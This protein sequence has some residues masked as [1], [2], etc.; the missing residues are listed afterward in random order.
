MM[1]SIFHVLIYHLYICFCSCV[2]L[3]TFF[4]CGAS[5][6]PL[7]SRYGSFVIY[8]CVVCKCFLPSCSLTFHPLNRIVYKKFWILMRPNLSSI[9]FYGSSFWVK[10]KNT[11]TDCLD[12]AHFMVSLHFFFFLKRDWERENTCEQGGAR[13]GAQ[14]QDWVSPL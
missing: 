5:R 12:L 10:S 9:S 14:P 4:N 8:I 2:L 11:F 6:V 3:T 1:L 13:H 7:C